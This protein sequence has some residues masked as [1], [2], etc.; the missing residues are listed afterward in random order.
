MRIPL[1]CAA[2]VLP[3]LAAANGAAP[4]ISYGPRPAYLIDKLPD[5]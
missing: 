5:G 3:T 2:L 4:Q 1:I